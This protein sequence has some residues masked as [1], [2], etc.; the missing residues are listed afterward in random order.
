MK[1]ELGRE[2]KWE[3]EEPRI[4][5]RA[6]QNFKAGQNRRKKLEKDCDGAAASEAEVKP[7]EWVFMGFW[8]LLRSQLK[9]F[10][11]SKNLIIYVHNKKYISK[12]REI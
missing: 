11:G 3:R 1:D 8:M 5:A 10:T 4:K 7:G 9:P 12:M 2:C 6:C